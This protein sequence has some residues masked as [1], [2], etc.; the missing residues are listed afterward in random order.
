MLPLFGPQLLGMARDVAAFNLRARVGQGNERSPLSSRILT[1]CGGKVYR[2]SS[3]A[4]PGNDINAGSGG[5]QKAPRWNPASLV[6]IGRA[7][8]LFVSI[9]PHSFRRGSAG[10]PRSLATVFGFS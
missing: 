1:I 4:G 9:P 5:S 8:R 3:Q 10:G 7:Q 6:C 2:A